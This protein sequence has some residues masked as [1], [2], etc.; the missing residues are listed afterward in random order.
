MT[1]PRL[2]FGFAASVLVFHQLPALLGPPTSQAIDLLTPFAVV[3][4]AAGLLVSLGAAG[5]PLVVGFVA[6]IL[7]VDAHGIHLAANSIAGYG[8]QG[9][10][11]HV[12][13]FLDEHFSHIELLAG[14]VGL[15][16][17]FALA[18]GR[19][20]EARPEPM[21]RALL[22]ATA[23]V[24]GWTFFTSTVEGQTWWL[25][26]GVAPVFA[27]WALRARR[28]IIVTAAVSYALAVALI[29]VWALVNGGVPEFSEVG[30][31]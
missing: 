21:S 9:A 7:Y 19:R 30:L 1:A 16:A 18:E 27:V 31:I 22:A 4:F 6:A 20:P 10:A 28:P 26:L 5:A 2:F 11:R 14:W 29:G 15:V 25:L 3:G 12:T 17:A 23:V 8:P 13:Y 24:L